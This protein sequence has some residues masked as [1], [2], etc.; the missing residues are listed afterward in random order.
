V[1]SVKNGVCYDIFELWGLR[2]EGAVQF[3]AKPPKTLVFE[4]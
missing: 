4:K 3:G 1:F 2:I